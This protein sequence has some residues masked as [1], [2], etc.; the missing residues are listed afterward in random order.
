MRGVVDD[1]SGDSMD[2]VMVGQIR[3]LHGFDAVCPDQGALYGILICQAHGLRAMGSGGCGEHLQV[4]RPRELG[5]FL[6]AF[7]LQP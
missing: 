6:A 2:A 5:E 4:K 7:R 3:K 1:G